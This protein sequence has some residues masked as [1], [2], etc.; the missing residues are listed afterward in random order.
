MSPIPGIQR[1][2]RDATPYLGKVVTVVSV[3]PTYPVVTGEL[4]RFATTQ[5]TSG[6]IIAGFGLI[7]YVEIETLRQGDRVPL[8]FAEYAI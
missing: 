3:N 1:F 6:L 2:I 7:P 8:R 4:L 5:T